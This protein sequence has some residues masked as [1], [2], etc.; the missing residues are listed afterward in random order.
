MDSTSLISEF[1][2]GDDADVFKGNKVRIVNEIPKK[3][4]VY[5]IMNIS[6]INNKTAS[7][8][9]IRLKEKYPEVSTFS[10]NFKFNTGQG[11]VLTP[12][13]D[14]KGLITILMLLPGEKAALFRYKASNIL[15]RYLAGDLSLIPE[16]EKNN[17]I[18]EINPDNFGFRNLIIGNNKLDKNTLPYIEELLT[19]TIIDT[20][21]SPHVVYLLWIG[22]CHEN[23]VHIW[24]FGHSVDFKDRSRIH[25]AEQKS[26]A[27]ILQISLGTHASNNLEKTIEKI[28]YKY[29]T[30]LNVEKECLNREIFVTRN[31]TDLQ[32]IVTKIVK[33]ANSDYFKKYVKDIRIAPGIISQSVLLKYDIK[34]LKLQY[35]FE[36]AKK[37]LELKNLEDKEILD[38]I[39][40]EVDINN[41]ELDEYSEISDDN[42]SEIEEDIVETYMSPV[43]PTYPYDSQEQ[44]ETLDEFIQK[45]CIVE[46]NKKM[47][48]YILF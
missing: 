10:R 18:Q 4:S 24:K 5:D 47:Q 11:Q 29:G 28:V 8:T 41:L 33:V 31:I 3:V 2:F 9:F 12:V 14:A 36:I 17:E 27:Y 13:V 20:F 23:N 44:I 25:K 45:F 42:V 32:D 46:E 22:F 7:K 1:I 26:E 6:G 43:L 38:N 39:L 37:H 34:R 35:E 40:D 19:P 15:V 16:I 21:L 30:K 48:K